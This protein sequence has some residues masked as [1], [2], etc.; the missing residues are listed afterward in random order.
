[1]ADHMTIRTRAPQ[2]KPVSIQPSAVQTGGGLC[3]IRKV[4]VSDE[5]KLTQEDLRDILDPDIGARTDQ[6]LLI[7]ANM[8][9]VTDNLPLGEPPAVQN[10]LY[11]EVSQAIL[12]GERFLI[13]VVPSRN[14]A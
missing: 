7:P 5:D 12:T 14:L 8:K 2:S 3:E 13:C 11:V 1:M 10:T 4:A 6:G 9:D